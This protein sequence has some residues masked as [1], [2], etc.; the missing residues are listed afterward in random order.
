MNASLQNYEQ[1]ENE[2]ATIETMNIKL[3]K[4]LSTK[5]NCARIQTREFLLS[6]TLI[7]N[8]MNGYYTPY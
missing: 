8:S 4:Y 2:M 5:E 3:H 6:G 1:E 7:T